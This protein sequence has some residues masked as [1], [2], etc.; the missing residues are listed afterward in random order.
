MLN[1]LTQTK[2]GEKMIKVDKDKN[3]DGIEFQYINLG[4]LIRVSSEMYEM[5]D[6]HYNSNIQKFSQGQCSLCAKGIKNR[7]HFSIICV[8]NQETSVRLDQEDIARNSGGFMESFQLG[9][10]CAKRVK[11]AMKESNLNWKDYLY[12]HKKEERA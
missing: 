2:Q 8:G 10:E 11:K 9:S 6:K 4:D 7:N 1:K 5:N 3:R 12:D